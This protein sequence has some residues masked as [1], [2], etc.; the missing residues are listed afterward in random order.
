MKGRTLKTTLTVL[1]VILL[2]RAIL[3]TGVEWYV[4]RALTK[5]ENYSGYVGDIDLNLWRGAYEI[6]DIRI[7][8]INSDLEIPF[9]AAKR[10]DLSLLWSALFRGALV[11]EIY[12]YDPE[13]NF[14]DGESE[15]KKQSGASENWLSI[16]DDLFPLKIDKLVIENGKISFSNLDAKP[17]IRIA[18]YDIEI[19]AY[20][21]ANN[22]S[23]ISDRTATA[24]GRAK[25]LGQGEVTI[26]AVASPETA[27]PT[28]DLNVEARQVALKVYEDLF[29]YYAPF[30]LEAG[31]LDLAAEI[32]ANE[33]KLKGYVKP[34]LNNVDVFSWKGDIEEDGKGFF[35]GLKEMLAGF[36]AEIFE[37]QKRD[38]LATK[39]PVE[40]T[41]DNIDIDNAAA[42]FGILRNAFVESIN[43]QVES[44]VSLEDAE[45]LEKTE[46][47]DQQK[48][49]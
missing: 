39:I 40:G 28:F 22:K 38:Q 37:N 10:L 44:T 26:S 34:V 2:I 15:G 5:A 32:A 23:G 20:N 4:N 47:E 24:S 43:A 29:N 25:T 13:I 19:E 7:V 33:G 21:L 12:A 6:E 14:T 17:P 31:T 8:K 30:T 45:S 35:G 3:P 41:I 36:L 16:A 1:A 42:F 48:K 27:K 9:F 46:K 49:E 11:G 18:L